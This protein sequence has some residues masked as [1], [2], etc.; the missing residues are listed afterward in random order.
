MFSSN[1]DAAILLFI[2][3]VVINLDYLCPSLSKRLKNPPS[4]PEHDI[5][6]MQRIHKTF[7]AHML[8]LTKELWAVFIFM[9]LTRMSGVFS[10]RG[11]LTEVFYELGW[12]VLVA[13]IMSYNDYRREA[14]NK[15]K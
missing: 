6:E 7:S 12:V 15:N 3:F 9:H 8:S 11:F 13:E 2:L 4:L 14:Q 5:E 10:T 1:L